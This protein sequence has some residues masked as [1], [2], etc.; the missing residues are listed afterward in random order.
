[1]AKNEHPGKPLRPTHQDKL[2]GVLN[3]DPA[4]DGQFF[5]AVKSTGIFCR[6]SCKS[7]N[8]KI[9]NIDFFDTSDDAQ[10]AGYRPCK[11]CRPD[12]LTYEPYKENVEAIYNAIM[13]HLLEQES[14]T[15]QMKAL[16]AHQD[17]IKSAFKTRYG[18]LPSAL[19]TQKRLSLAAD[20]LLTTTKPILQI[21]LDSGFSSQSA[22]YDAFKRTYHTSPGKY[23]K[24]NTNS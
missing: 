1:M 13:T 20:G 7:K 10:R 18:S 11:R 4:Y 14:L 3:S 8:P 2:A 23:R 22:F 19:I 24:Q 5:Y 17:P 15:A 21:A 12:L 9:E 16:G 6:P